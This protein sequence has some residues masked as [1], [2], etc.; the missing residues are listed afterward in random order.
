MVHYSYEI[1]DG[2]KCY[3][4]E[5]AIDNTYYPADAFDTLYKLEQSNFWF[6]A[7]NRLIF[8]LFNKYIN[9]EKVLKT[10]EIGCGTGFVL[11]DLKKIQSLKLYGAEILLNGLKLASKRVPE[12]EFIQLDVTNMQF[13]S[14][15]DII[16]TFDV[17]EHIKEDRKAISNIYKALKENGLFFI[18]VPQHRFL[19]AEIDELSNHKRRY[20][21]SELIEKLHKSDFEVLYNTSFVFSLFPVMVLSRMF[22]RKR[23]PYDNRKEPDLFREFRIPVIANK[24]FDVFMYADEL[25]IKSGIR[26]PFGG[27]LF[28]I[29][30]K[31]RI[32]SNIDKI[33]MLPHI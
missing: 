3:N 4:P 8:Y 6:K 5:A 2:V 10:L 29:A 19:W 31:K 25:L 30:S 24:I 13:V 15:F 28:V 23:K 20:K 21:K 12:A 11:S 7:R 14:E 27:S 17:L 1:I 18:T 33:N 26:F 16:C 9:K 22:N 32:G